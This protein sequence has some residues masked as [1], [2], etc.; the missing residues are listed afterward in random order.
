MS[1]LC[2]GGGELVDHSN[3]APPHGL[4]PPTS[5]ERMLTTQLIMKSSTDR[6]IV[7]AP[8]VEMRLYT[9]HPCPEA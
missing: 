6:A 4:L 2:A 8:M 7:N 1:K 9:S 3:V 5:P